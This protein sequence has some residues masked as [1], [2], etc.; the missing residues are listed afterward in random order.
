MGQIMILLGLVCN[1]ILGLSIGH[2]NFLF[3]SIT[4]LIKLAMSVHMNPDAGDDSSYDGLQQQIL[5]DLPTSLY[6]AMQ[7]LKVDGKTVLYAACPSCHHIHPPTLSATKAPTW[8]TECENE[9][10]GVDGRSRCSTALLVETK[11]HPR[12]IRPFLSHSFLDYLAR[13]LSTPEIEKEVDRACDDALAWKFKFQGKPEFVD[14]VLH[15]TFVQEFEGP[16][17]KLFIDR[18]EDKKM[19]LLF[20]F[21]LDFFPPRGSRRRSSSASIGVLTVYCANL[22]LAIRQK[23]ENLYVS[24]L[25]GPNG[26]HKEHI[27]PYLRPT[28]DIGVAG[29][30]RGIHLS[31][32]GA[33]PETGRTL[34]L[35]FAYAVNDLPAA[36]DVAGAAGHTSNHFCTVCNLHG[37]RETYRTDC[38][39][40][41]RRDVDEMRSQAEAWRDA[42]TL[43]ERKKIFKDTGLRYSEMWRLP[44]WDPTRMLVPEFMHC[45]LEGIAH[46]HV[47]RVLGLTAHDAQKKDELPPAF[48]YHF[49]EFD[50]ETTELPESVTPLPEGMRNFERDIRG[51]HRLLV[52]SFTDAD[53]GDD[54]ASDGSS[55]SE[56]GS[57]GDDPD[58][59]AVPNTGEVEEFTEKILCG[60]L[61][62]KLKKSLMFV[63]LS[64]NLWAADQPMRSHEENLKLAKK[65]ALAKALVAWVSLFAVQCDLFILIFIPLAFETTAYRPQIRSPPKNHLHA[66]P[67]LRSKRHRKYYHPVVGAPCPQKLRREGSWHSEGGRVASH[68]HHIS[69]HRSYV[70]M[71]GDDR[72]PRR[73]FQPAPRP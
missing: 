25:T 13:L 52:R 3:S 4:L 73:S 12:P 14:N 5:L 54:A 23:P 8:P 21:S 72:G 63:C 6:T 62:K 57:H 15:G 66:R 41:V 38:E 68:E 65:G 34:N 24:I 53:T 33:S 32:T 1:V 59:A 19:R 67:S 55:E 20:G 17:G 26:P 51:I 7:R 44:Y 61:T 43:D 48:H 35:A 9:I 28:V 29:W 58:T 11:T 39:N 64:L 60:R 50:Q 16:D 36:R 2:T 22:S 42:D 56:T 45:G 47:R 30:E 10:V 40:W 31:K 27:N 49:L 69:A 37:R 18:G 70:V 71:G 46:Y